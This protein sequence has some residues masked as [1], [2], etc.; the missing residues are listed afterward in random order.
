MLHCKFKIDSKHFT[1]ITSK[2]Q[3]SYDPGSLSQV[4]HSKAWDSKI[5]T[6]AWWVYPHQVSKTAPTGEYLTVGSFMIRGKKN[7]L[8]PHPLVMG[9]GILFRLDESSLAAHLNERRVKG[10][11]EALQEIEAESHKKQSNPQSDDEIASENG[12]D[13]ETHEDESSRENTNI[14]R[15]N[16]LGLSDRSTD[17]GTVTSPEILAETEVEE[18]LDNGN[19]S[20]KEETGDASVS[21]ELADLLDKTLGLGPTKV[22]GKSSLITSIPSSLAE[23]ND[24]LEVKKPAVR[25][26]P[27][28][29]KAERRKLKKGQSTGETATYSQYGE[30]VETPDASQQEKGNANTKAGSC[31]S[32]PGTSQQAKGKANTKATGSKVSQPGSSQQEKGKGSTQAANPKVSRGQKGKLKKI[33]EKYAEQDE[34]EREIRMALLAV[35]IYHLSSFLLCCPFPF[36]HQ[37]L[38]FSLIPEVIWQTFAKGQSFTR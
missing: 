5:V 18:N 31:V 27:Y 8:P 34:E 4:C 6:S 15:T 30:A 3:C 2:C 29:S 36:V 13:K 10:E 25:D 9:F 7:F 12:S 28:I 33:K 38:T 14:D 23:D 19:S 21:S 24:D 20:S 17:I 32:E 1:A 22:S 37:V 11:D 35:I 16:N 26:K